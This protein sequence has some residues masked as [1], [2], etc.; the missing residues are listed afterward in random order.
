MEQV[1]FYNQ[2][3]F[4]HDAEKTFLF[5]KERIKEIIPN[6][7]VQHVGST[8]IPNSLTKGDLDIQ[9]RISTGQFPQAVEALSTLYESNEGSIKTSEFRA[10]K[11]DLTNP[12]LG[13]Q[14][15]LIGSEFDFFWKFRDALLQNDPYRVEYDN[16]KRQ[17]EAES[18]EDYRE[19]KN[20]FFDKIKQT[21][22]FKQLKTRR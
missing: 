16:L 22:E 21:P 12:P 5:Q 10:F 14:L 8:A 6:V 3:I 7:D 17:F 11:S 15:N 4:N 20:D 1:N 13:I 9:V 19:A 2:Q 18:M